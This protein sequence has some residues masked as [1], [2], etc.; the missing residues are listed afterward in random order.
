M[1][2]S[3]LIINC[4]LITSWTCAKQGVVF[5]KGIVECIMPIRKNNMKNCNIHFLAFLITIGILVLH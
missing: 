1:N 3:V 4:E 2:K 5:C